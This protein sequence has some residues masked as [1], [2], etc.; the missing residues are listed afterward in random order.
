MV[1][2]TAAPDAIDD[3]AAP[4]P[5][6]PGAQARERRPSSSSPQHV[7]YAKTHDGLSYF[8][9]SPVSDDS[10]SAQVSISGRFQ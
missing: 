8:A 2:T 3:E 10:E 1:L 9:L 6:S 4:T 7:K 5:D